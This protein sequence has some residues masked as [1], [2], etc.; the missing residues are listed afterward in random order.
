MLQV[1]LFKKK[2][3]LFSDIT[4]TLILGGAKRNITINKKKHSKHF[5]IVYVMSS[6]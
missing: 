3:Y 4:L 5:L 2:I 6:V 1:E